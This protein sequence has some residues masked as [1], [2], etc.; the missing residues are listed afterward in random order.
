MSNGSL[1]RTHHVLAE[2]L[3]QYSNSEDVWDSYIDLAMFSYN[4][5]VHEGTK[6]TPYELVFGKLARRPSGEPLTQGEQLPTYQNYL[7]DLVKRLINIQKLAHD[8]LI[9]AKEKSK[10]YY[11]KSSYPQE[12]KIGSNVFL[13]K[14]NKPGKLENHYSGPYKVLQVFENRNVKIKT[15]KGTKVVH[16]NRLKHSHINPSK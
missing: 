9:N 4:N 13:L 2:Y 10:E 6:F 3:K 1:E 5:S 8:K 11:D 14:G 7:V 15:E 16:P 12:F